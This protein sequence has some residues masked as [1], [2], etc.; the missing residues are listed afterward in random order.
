[1]ESARPSRPGFLTRSVA[2]EGKK[3]F[4]ILHT[5]DLHSNLIG[6]A[7]VLD[8]APDKANDDGDKTLGGFARLATVIAERKSARKDLGPVLVL[9]GGDYSM[10]TAFGAATR[11]TGAELQLLFQMGYDAVTFGNHDFDLGSDG[12]GQSIGVAAKAGRVPAVVASNT[13]FLAHDPTLADLQR[14]AKDGVIRRYLVIERGGIRFGV[15]GVLGKEAIFFASAAGAASFDDPFEAAKEVVAILRETE[16]V[17]VVICLSHGGVAKGEDG[18]YT[19]GDDIRVAQL[20]PGIDVVVGGHSHILLPEPI[21]V[22]D[23]TPVVQAGKYG[24]HLGELVITVDGGRLTVES[25]QIHAIDNTVLGDR[26]IEDEIEELKK[27]VT[28]IVFASRGYSFDQPLAVAPRDVCCTYTDIAASTPLANLVTD[29]FRNATKADIGMTAAALI[30]TGLTRGTSGVQTVYDVFAVTPIGAGVVDSTAGSALVTAYFTGHELKNVLEFLLANNP[31]SGELFPR[32]SGMKFHYD[33]A[34]PKYDVVTAIEIGD[35]DRGYHAIDISG[36]DEQLYSV[37]TSLYMGKVVTAIP[38]YSKG[39]LPVVAKNKNGQPLTSRS[40]ALADPR[41]D[42]PDLLA[43]PAT[44]D[45]ASIDTVV[46]NG[47]VREIKE[48]QAV[49]DHIRAL[50]VKSVG[51]LPVIPVD[52]R[53]TE[54]RAVRVKETR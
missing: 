22:N 28:E 45:T 25:Y 10:G 16:H 36:N 54:V 51:E 20:V 4:T 1:V 37:T 35:L 18:R 50:P 43:P 7:P 49:M 11:E 34:R 19:D 12:L 52:G 53:A 3:T 29:A 31:D 39:E 46:Q 13:N 23:R 47:S 15:F 24:E 2:A 21:M 27:T 8:Y 38:N 32:A 5:N 30:R 14:L 42:T 44:T 40:D 41:R 9:D 48:W 26:I 17:D 33:P 6:M